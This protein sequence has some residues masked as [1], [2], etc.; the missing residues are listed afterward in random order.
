[1]AARKVGSVFRTLNAVVTFVLTIGV[2]FTVEMPSARACSCLQYYAWPV[3]PTDGMTN[4]PL[5]ATLIIAASRAQDLAYAMTDASGNVI[6]LRHVRTLD[7]GEA[8]AFRDHVFLRPDAELAPNTRYT[9]AP[10]F[11]MVD[12]RNAPRASAASFTT[13]SERASEPTMSA[14]LW[15]YAE[16]TH[17]GRLM[18]VFAVVESDRPAFVAAPGERL[19][20]VRQVD[21]ATSPEPVAIPLGVVPCANVEVVDATGTTRHSSN[22]C[23]P[24]KCVRADS[25]SISSCGDHPIDRSWEAW[26]SVPNGCEP[27]SAAGSATPRGCSVA[28]RTSWPGAFLPLFTVLGLYPLLRARPSQRKRCATDGHRLKQGGKD[29]QVPE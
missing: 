12:A 22:V 16:Q 23:Q 21:S 15:V 5:N 28:G 10:S 9:L 19:V 18:Q 7:A 29:G 17:L 8:C 24:Q 26:Q 2:S 4:V 27:M 3:W 14:N 20:V 1:M 11:P 13:G 6:E 25:Y